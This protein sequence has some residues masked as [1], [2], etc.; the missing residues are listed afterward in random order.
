MSIDSLEWSLDKRDAANPHLPNI[1][2]IVSPK[3]KEL[4]GRFGTL[5]GFDLTFGLIT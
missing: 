2:L 4:Y 1:L 5:I 3:M